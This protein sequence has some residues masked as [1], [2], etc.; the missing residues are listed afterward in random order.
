MDIRREKL[1]TLIGKDF[2]KWTRLLDEFSDS[3]EYIDDAKISQTCEDFKNVSIS[4][5]KELFE[6][7]GYLDSLKQMSINDLGV[8]FKG[9]P[10]DGS[11]VTHEEEVARA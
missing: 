7:F 10:A 3:I 6:L 4:L 5:V 8:A 11:N 1:E 2:L 9:E